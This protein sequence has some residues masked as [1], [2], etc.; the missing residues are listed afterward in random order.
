MSKP[1]ALSINTLLTF[2]MQPV[3]GELFFKAKVKDLFL[4]SS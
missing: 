3:N 1:S 4:L 2:D